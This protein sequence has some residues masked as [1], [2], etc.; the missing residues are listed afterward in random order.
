V[1]RFDPESGEPAVIS[2]RTWMITYAG[3]KDLAALPT[4]F[5]FPEPK[6]ETNE[7]SYM[8]Y[9]DADLKS[10]ALTVSLEQ[11]Y[12]EVRARWPW[13]VAAIVPV[14]IAGGLGWRAWSRRKGVAGAEGPVLPERL[15]AFNVL[16]LLRRVEENN[17]FDDGRKRELAD[18][19][20]SLERFYFSGTDG[21]QPP[22]LRKLAERWVAPRR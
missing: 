9:E 11:K 12:G 14:L 3:R 21:Q 6:V 19:I 5:H 18:N 20:A 10:V 7:T 15:T 16:A 17:G 1:S 2:E 13:V 8:R 4:T 22:D